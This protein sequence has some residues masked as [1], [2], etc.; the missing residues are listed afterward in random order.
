MVKALNAWMAHF[1]VANF[2]LCEYQ[3][4]KPWKEGRK[5]G[6]G[7]REGGRNLSAHVNVKLK[8]EPS[9]K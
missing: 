7:G 4:K 3:L 1:K 2:I 8:K 6:S 9:A 5:R